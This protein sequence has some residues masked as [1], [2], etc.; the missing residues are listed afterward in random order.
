MQILLSWMME[1]FHYSLLF[2]QTAKFSE[3]MIIIRLIFSGY[4]TI[5]LIEYPKSW[6]DTCNVS[7][8]EKNVPRL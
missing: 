7:S 4:E 3:H 8:K 2:Q 6:Q 1:L 5:G